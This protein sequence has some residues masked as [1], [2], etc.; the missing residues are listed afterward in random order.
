VYRPQPASTRTDVLCMYGMYRDPDRVSRTIAI[1]V[2]LAL[3]LAVGFGLFILGSAVAGF[4]GMLM[5]MGLVGLA[6]TLLLGK[7]FE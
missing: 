4:F 6:G 1:F 2:G 5:V 7:L 3:L